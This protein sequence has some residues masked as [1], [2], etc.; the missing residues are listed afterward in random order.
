MSARLESGPEGERIICYDPRSEAITEEIACTPPGAVAGC[1]ARARAAQ[2]AWAALGL[3]DRKA[4]VAALRGRFL[5]EA[6]TA[7]RLL[8]EE[9]GRPPGEAWTS[10]VVANAS[11]FGWWLA[12]ID[13]LLAPAPLNLSPID[14]PKKT[15]AVERE[16]VGVVGLITPWNLPVAIPLRTLV[17]AL[18][19]GNTVV[20]KPSE[21]TARL[22]AWLAGLC[23][24]ALGPDIVVL[25]QGGRVAG[26]ALVDAAPDHL[27]FTGSVRAGRQI[28]ARAAEKLTPVSLEL[29]GKDAAIVCADAELDRAAAGIVWAAYA[30]G[31]QNCAAVERCFVHRSV[32]EA[33]LTDA[34]ARTRALRPGEDLGPLVTAAQKET[35]ERHL[36]DALARGARVVAQ[37]P[38]GPGQSVPAT[39][40]AD[41]PADA[42]LW[43]EE[44][45]GPLLPV[46]PFDDEADAVRR[47][48][49]SAYG[50]TGSV[51]T[52]DLTRGERLARQLATGVAT[53]N[54]HSFTGAVAEA[55]WTGLKDS[56]HGVTNSPHALAAFTRPRTVLVDALRGPR[57][58]WWYP[59]TPALNVLSRGLVALQAPGRSRLQGVRDAL[60]GLLNRWKA[61]P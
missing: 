16:P 54:N 33:F 7:V 57:E 36:A 22:G 47:A 41:V 11:L 50:L 58:L 21:H 27:V 19:A 40:L 25:V 23:T 38:T 44:T 1:V 59:Y 56:G 9:C 49:D 13:A 60:T 45:F 18:L 52:R 5:Q 10:E 42:L 61:T 3:A 26:E 15:G 34:A 29:G 4:R 8:A 48:N 37:S 31:G 28:T 55:A 32:Y 43:T 12:Q 35:V 39:L 46:V 17:P 20:W 30:F 53:V 51:W 14:Y 24:A 2:P 6:D